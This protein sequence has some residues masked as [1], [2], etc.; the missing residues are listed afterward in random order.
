[1]IVCGYDEGILGYDEDLLIKGGEYEV[2]DEKYDL[3]DYSKF[4]A[5]CVLPVLGENNQINLIYTTFLN[6]L[7]ILNDLPI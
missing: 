2:A 3:K 5:K 6:Q 7:V 1:M 4:G